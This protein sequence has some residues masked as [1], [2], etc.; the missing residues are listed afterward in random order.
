MHINKLKKQTPFNLF[1]LKDIQKLFNLVDFWLSYSKIIFGC[2][3]D[4]VYLVKWTFI[5]TNEYSILA[6]LLQLLVLI[7]WRW[8]LQPKNL[9][10][11]LPTAVVRVIFML[12][13]S[14]LGV[15]SKIGWCCVVFWVNLYLLIL[16]CLYILMKPP[17]HWKWCLFE[18]DYKLYGN[19]RQWMSSREHVH[20][21]YFCWKCQIWF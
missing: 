11:M 5:S 2:F 17:V 4:T 18:R 15:I 20:D 13:C 14:M 19:K 9:V 1:F 10:L 3:W 8:S 6:W 7:Q 16:S 12:V 21:K